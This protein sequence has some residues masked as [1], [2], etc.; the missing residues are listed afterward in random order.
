MENVQ[1]HLSYSSYMCYTVK[2]LGLLWYQGLGYGLEKFRCFYNV[3]YTLN[4]MC[5]SKKHQVTQLFFSK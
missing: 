5:F 4:K 2:T 1:Q 3:V